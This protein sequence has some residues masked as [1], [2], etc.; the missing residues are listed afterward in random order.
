[1]TGTNGGLRNGVQSVPL[2]NVRGVKGFTS[3]PDAMSVT[4][5]QDEG[6]ATVTFDQ[7]VD[8]AFSGDFDAVDRFGNVYVFQ[9]QAVSL[10]DGNRVRLQLPAGTAQQAVGIVLH[11]GAVIGT[12]GEDSVQ[13][14]IG[15]A[16]IPVSPG[17]GP[18]VPAA[19]SVAPQG[20]TSSPAG[21]AAASNQAVSPAQVN[22]SPAKSGQAA[23]K[24]GRISSARVVR[25]KSGKYVLLIKVS[26]KAKT[27]KVR[28]RTV[29]KK[30]KVVRTMVR[31]VKTNKTVRISGLKL[32]QGQ[33][34]RASLA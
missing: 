19:P 17:P 6:S 24:S 32:H 26:S 33:K 4:F 25:T 1:V 14:A 29:T 11:D 15:R 2:G 16:V 8:T 9:P 12:N 21:T 30:G 7:D 5:D 31:R 13:Q 23:K 27:A 10:I 34:L 20:P 3:A 28:L 18:L 22:V